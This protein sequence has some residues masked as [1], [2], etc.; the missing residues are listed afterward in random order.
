MNDHQVQLGDGLHDG[1]VHDPLQDLGINN[2]GNDG[3][4]QDN[5][6]AMDVDPEQG[7]MQQDAD[8]ILPAVKPTPATAG[9]QRVPPF[10]PKYK[11]E[12]SISN[13]LFSFMV[14]AM[15][16]DVPEAKWA[17]LAYISCDGKASEWLTNSI[18]SRNLQ[19]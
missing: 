13:F 14:H 3:Q 10:T 11:G 9:A 6:E 12:Y 16:H 2:D 19:L 15:L 17:L 7:G 4:N 18:R 5:E 1:D 8:A